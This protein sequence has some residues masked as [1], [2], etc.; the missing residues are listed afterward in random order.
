MNFRICIFGLLLGMT[1]SILSGQ[2]KV[3][4][5]QR[6]ETFYSIART[7]GIK[8]EDLMAHNGITDPT[9]LQA[10][11]RLRIPDSGTA[12]SGGI[13]FYKAVRGD[14]LFGIARKF[15]VTVGAIQEANNLQSNYVLKEGDT[16][17]IPSVTGIPA[18]A[19]VPAVV[20]AAPVAGSPSVG[21]SSVGNS[22][23]GGLSWP[24][25]AREISYMTGKLSGVVITGTRNEPVT[26]LTW[27]T[28]L[29]AGPYRGFGRVVIVQVEGGYLYVYGGCESLSVKE[30]DRVRAG[31]E[32]G[33]LGVDAVSNKPQLF[34]MV[35]RSNSPID[36][37]EAPRA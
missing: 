7:L 28:V 12:D 27:G 36:P 15:S 14:T 32:I 31:T 16:L 35:Y 13:S 33:K 4:T 6:G 18:A 30:G 20:A 3:H 26:S 19:P 22:S 24:V 23:V 11:Q 17:R 1:A 37:A 9:R 10:G 29:S 34:F 8:A 5:V 25:A 21:N 2:E